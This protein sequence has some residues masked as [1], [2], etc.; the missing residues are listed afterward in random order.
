MN[1]PFRPDVRAVPQRR[2]RRGMYILP[3][4]FTCGNI[5]L[6]FYAVLQTMHA[7]AIDPQRYDMAAM[8]IGFAILFDG[9]DGRIARMTNTVS[10]FGKE[11]DSLADVITFGVAPALLAYFWGFGQLASANIDPGLADRVQHLGAVVAF[12]FLVSGASRLARFNITKNP[13]PK[14]PGRPG[15]KY[16]V[17]MPI[18]A[19]AGIIAAV[20]H[21]SRDPIT[22]W[23]MGL[24]WAA[25]VFTIGYLMVS[26]WRFYSGKDLD[27]RQR[28]PFYLV[29]AIAAFIA[30]VRYFSQEVLLALAL[31]YMA[32]GVFFRIAYSIRRRPQVPPT[33][34]ADSSSAI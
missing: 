32:S 34:A 29:I 27:F 33:P 6:G 15:R 19:G 25:F 4:L 21:F 18:P 2:G 17:G 8:L 20:V 11:L 26:T 31:L 16:F 28:H 5:A 30:L 14:N 22:T 7:S 10:D 23:W 3:S 1:L 13:Q 9:L 12:L 24:L